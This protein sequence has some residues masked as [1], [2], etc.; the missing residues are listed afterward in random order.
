M[1]YSTKFKRISVFKWCKL[2]GFKG[3]CCSNDGS[4]LDFYMFFIFELF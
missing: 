4:L 1:F 2:S 3:G